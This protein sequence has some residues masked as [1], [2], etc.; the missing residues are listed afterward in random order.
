MKPM[1]T[2]KNLRKSFGSKVVLDN[3]EFELTAG[4]PIA[5]IGPNGA[6]KTT[7]FSILCGYLSP[8]A[9]D[10]TLFGQQPGS[11]AL[12]GKVG[13]LPQDALFDPNFSLLTQ[14][15]FFAQLQGMSKTQAQADAMRVLQLV[16]LADYAKQKP[17]ALS[18]GMKKRLAIAQALLGEPELVLLDE[19]TAG[20]DPMNAMQI[21]Q[22]IAAMSQQATFVISSH[23]LFELERLCGTI[24]YLEHGRLVQQRTVQSGSQQGFLTLTMESADPVQVQKILASVPGVLKVEI[25]QKHEYLIW[26]D[27][28]LSPDTDLAILQQLRS[29]GLRYKSL[30]RGQSLEQQ[31]FAVVNS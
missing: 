8:D 28:E 27:S 25:P 3:L 9:G 22:L 10:I 20:L 16:D 6:G 11:S 13:A 17:T 24:L 15:S 4:E 7:L 12:F 5:L 31:L 21:R 30:Q 19:P 18:H 23:N 1:I 29:A 14:L 26:F 2:A